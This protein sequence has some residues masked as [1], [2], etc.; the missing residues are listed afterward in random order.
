M[1]ETSSSSVTLSLTSTPPPSSAAFQLT[2]KSLR[3]VT[4]EPSPPTRWL[5]DAVVPDRVGP[6]GGVL[7]GDGDR[8]GH[9][10]DRQVAGH[11]ELGVTGRLDPGRHEGDLRVL[12]HR[13]EVVA[14]QVLVALAVAGV[15]ALRLDRHAPGRVGRVLAVDVERA[16]E[17]VERAAHL[18]H[19]R[20]PRAEPDPGV[21]GVDR[22]V[23]GQSG[24]LVGHRSYLQR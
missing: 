24:V 19:H 1:A 12:V 11:H 22:V 10:T 7:E 23:T 2:P 20:V 18:G 8:P 5:R 15:D 13:Q 6:R 17:L 14:A 16:L 4:T 3:L 21:R 9:A